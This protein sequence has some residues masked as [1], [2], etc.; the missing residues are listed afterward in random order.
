MQV[1]TI[2]I[3]AGPNCDGQILVTHDMIGLFTRFRPRFVR[4][5]MALAEDLHKAFAEFVGD[6]KS[7]DFPGADESY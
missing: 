5:Y 6:V 4:R 7:R 3:G 1:P 2:G